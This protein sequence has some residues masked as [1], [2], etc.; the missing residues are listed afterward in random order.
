MN[1]IVRIA[2]LGLL[3]SSATLVQAQSASTEDF[4]GTST[5]N[6]WYYFNG[7]CLTAGTGNSNGSNGTIAGPIPGCK[8]ILASY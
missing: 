3:V 8:N 7:A 6:S 4:T 5:T 1:A 2:L